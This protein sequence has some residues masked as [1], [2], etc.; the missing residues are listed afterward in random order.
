[1]RVA[2][3]EASHW[4]IPLYLDALQVPG[5]EVVAVSDAE[6]VKGEEIARRFGSALY[7]SS[8]ALLDREKIDFAFAFGRHSEMPAIA[9]S[10][11]A[12]RIP[13]A[14]QKP[15]AVRSEQVTRLRRLADAADLYVAVPFIFRISDLLSAK[16]EVEGRIPSDFH[17]MAIRFIVGP[18]SRYEA[19]G[20]GWALDPELAGGG[21]TINVATHF[22]D[23]FRLLTG[24][25]ITR[26][27]AVMNSRTHRG[28]VE[29]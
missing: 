6:H 11:I 5:I 10:L 20:A 16:R 18:P 3:L 27:S 26:V 29:D 9:G 14:L 1:M 19:A 8:E 22:I 15:C 24:K 17:Y 12:R 21:S 25:D 28:S 13:F 7:P 4:H 23:L 2:L